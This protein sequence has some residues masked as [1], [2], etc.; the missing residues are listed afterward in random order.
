M[1]HSYFA[2]WA[3]AQLFIKSTD[4]DILVAD[5]QTGNL[6]PSIIT[7]TYTAILN[8]KKEPE[9][10]E[11]TGLSLVGQDA[12]KIYVE[13]YLV[14]PKQFPDTL[15]LSITCEA[16]INNIDGWLYLPTNIIN[17][18]GS[19]NRLGANTGTRLMGWFWQK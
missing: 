8:Q 11:K 12:Y 10:I 1:T 4:T 14:N 5:S 19:E 7:T 2:R 15:K 18:Y 6:V 13:G 3:N 16:T 9:N 17:S